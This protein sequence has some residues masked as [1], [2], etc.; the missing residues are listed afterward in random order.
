MYEKAIIDSILCPHQRYSIW[1]N[2]QLVSVGCQTS[3]SDVPNST[4][5]VI[6]P[7]Q[8]LA[9]PGKKTSHHREGCEKKTITSK[10]PFC[11]LIYPEKEWWFQRWFPFFVNRKVNGYTLF[12]HTS[13]SEVSAQGW[14]LQ[15][16]QWK[17]SF[18]V[19]EKGAWTNCS[20][21]TNTNMYQW[22]WNE[23]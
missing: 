7:H 4:N 21:R 15:L 20:A 11:S 22:T 16:E 6:L 8:W 2:I 5:P 10:D 14:E 3:I 13:Q 1:Y 17:P 19:K 23:K 12:H 18:A 9:L